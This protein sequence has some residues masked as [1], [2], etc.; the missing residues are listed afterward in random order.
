MINIFLEMNCSEGQIS[1][2][3]GCAD[4]QTNT[5]LCVVKC[6]SCAYIIVTALIDMVLLNKLLPDLHAQGLTSDASIL[7]QP[8]TKTVHIHSHPAP[9]LYQPSSNDIRQP[10]ST[11]GTVT[12]TGLAVG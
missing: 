5:A 8:Y 12:V 7:L 3:M 9:T 11:V 10:R 6:C 2:H 4:I 1:R